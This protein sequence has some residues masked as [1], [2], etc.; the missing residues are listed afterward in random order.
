MSIPA[1]YGHK[2]GY[3]EH[4]SVGAGFKSGCQSSLSGCFHPDSE[5]GHR[6]AFVQVLNIKRYGVD[7]T[8]AATDIVEFGSE[9]KIL[10]A[11]VFVPGTIGCRSSG[12]GISTG[13]VT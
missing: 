1:G 12:V 6:S 10:L 4:F 8:G 5:V 7:V 11:E 2:L 3:L 13:S 9:H